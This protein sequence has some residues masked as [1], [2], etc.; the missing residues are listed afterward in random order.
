MPSECAR[1]AR[2]RLVVL[3]SGRGTNLGS[4]LDASHEG[5]MEADVVLVV[6]NRAD[7]LAIEIAAKKGIPTRV[8]PHDDI[9]REEHDRLVLE[10]V[11][12]ARPD[13]V[14][15][16]GYMRILGDEMVARYRGRMLNI[17]P[18]L[19]PAFRGLAA[20]LAAHVKG[21]RIVGCTVH[22]VTEELDGG[23]ILAQAAR[24]VD[25][26]WD[27]DDVRAAILELEHKLYPAAVQLL[28]RGGAR[29]VEDRVVFQNVAAPDASIFSLEVDG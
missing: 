24:V 3:V 6:S 10:A 19:L 27:S 2:L 22:F 8:V 28:V 20:P 12:D 15:L 7:A 5:R 18:S 21:V 23:P 17:H 26:T 1:V 11:D 9:S 4:L 29:L 14:I 13:L 25:P 16:A